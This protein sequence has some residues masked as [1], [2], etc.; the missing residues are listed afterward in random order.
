ML[1]CWCELI[2]APWREVWEHPPNHRR[3][4][5]KALPPHF[6]EFL[7]TSTCVKGQKHEISHCVTVCL[8]RLEATEMFINNGWWSKSYHEGKV[9]RKEGSLLFTD[10]ERS[11]RHNGKWKRQET[12]EKHIITYVKGEENKETRSFVWH[13]QTKNFNLKQQANKSKLRDIL[14]NN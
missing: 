1:V 6:Q 8:A 12:E 2:Q 14:H 3:T 13:L 7:W 9:K 11:A 10:M 5:P 4:C